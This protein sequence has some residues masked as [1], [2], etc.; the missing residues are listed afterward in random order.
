MG[1]YDDPDLYCAAFPPP[2]DAEVDAVL[3]RV[4][5]PRSLL[6]PFCGHARLAEPIA[7]RGVAYVGLDASPQ[8][9]A[10]P[11][12]ACQVHHHRDQPDFSA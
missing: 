3:R 6:E 8:I 5:S 4:A 7:A 9:A 2:T 1:I 10:W 11:N 12:A